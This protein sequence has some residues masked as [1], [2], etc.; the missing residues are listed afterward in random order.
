MPISR[1]KMMPSNLL[2]TNI[3]KISVFKQAIAAHHLK[4]VDGS[5][6]NL[7]NEIV[8]NKSLLP[9]SEKWRGASHGREMIL[10]L[11]ETIAYHEE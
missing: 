7:Y 6:W 8:E 11:A 1:S 5:I 10:L 2:S 4:I 9:E 3:C